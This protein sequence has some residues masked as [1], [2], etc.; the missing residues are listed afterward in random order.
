MNAGDKALTDQ[1][2][3]DM[4]YQEWLDVLRSL[5]IA[6]GKPVEKDRLKIYAKA[7]SDVPLGLLEKAVKRVQLSMTYNIVPTIA[8]IQKAINMELFLANCN[9]ISE[10]TDTE[11]TK[12]VTL[13]HSHEQTDAE[14]KRYA[15][16]SR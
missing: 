12:P 16:P 3:Y 8:E 7:F 10:W 1:Q 14:R 13:D 4:A 5:W 6:I 15:L 9:D 11:W 2:I